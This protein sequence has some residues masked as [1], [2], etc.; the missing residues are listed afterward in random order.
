MWNRNHPL[1]NEIIAAC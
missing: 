1:F